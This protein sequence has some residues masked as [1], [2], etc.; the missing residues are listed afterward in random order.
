MSTESLGA[1]V[2]G[3]GRAGMIHARNLV[4]NIPNARLVALADAH[5][6][7]LQK[8]GTELGIKRKYTDYR[9]ALDDKDVDAVF[10]VTPTVFHREIVVQAAQAGKHVFCEKPMAMNEAEC[11]EMIKASK[12]A[13]TK[14]QIG[15]M[16]RFDKSFKHAKEQLASGV[17]GQVEQIKSVTHGP[18]KPQEWMFDIRKSNGPLAEVN[19]HDIDTLRWFSESE[20]SEVYG[21]AGNFRC[22]EVSEKY[23][24]FYDSV[25][26]LCRFSNGIQGCIDG[27]VSVGYG[28]DARTEVL[29]TDGILFVGSIRENN[30]VRCTRDGGL[31][32]KAIETWRSLFRDAYE[33]EDRSFIQCVF[34]NR[35]PEVTGFD[36]L[37]AV[38]IVNA[39]NKSIRDNKPVKLQT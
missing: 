39:G 7:G 2:I 24:D 6:D 18:S 21:M 25:L 1:C 31:A 17:I 4:N 29:G 38:R 16:R 9:K 5:G 22:T 26:L 33:N 14:L 10:V 32:S 8:A 13:G 3:T 36:G 34:D 35:E 27:A 15:F 23:P 19:S 30:V 11:I 12:A 20:I 37:Q 28:Y